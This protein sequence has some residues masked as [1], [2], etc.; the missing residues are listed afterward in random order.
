MFQHHD[1][2]SFEI[3]SGLRSIWDSVRFNKWVVV[4]CTV[5]TLALLILYVMLWPP[6]YQAEATLM[7]EREH[8]PTRDVYYSSWNVFRKDDARTELALMGSGAVLMELVD[9]EK[10]TYADVHHTFLD[11][12]KFLW[13][14]SWPGRRY[15][16]LKA[17]INPPPPGAVPPTAE[18]IDRGRTLEAIKKSVTVTPVAESNVGLLMVKAPSPKAAAIANTLLDTYLKHRKIRHSAEAQAAFDVLA[19]EVDRAAG[20]VEVAAAKRLAFLE[21]HGLAFDFNQELQQQQTLTEMEATVSANRSKL[22]GLEASLAK[23]EEQLAAETP[24]KKLATTVQLN[25][26][27]ESAK[28]KRLELQMALIHLEGRYRPDAPEVVEVKREIQELDRI[29]AGTAENIESGSTAGLN[30]IHENLLVTRNTI[31]AELSGLRAAIPSMERSAARLR[32]HL[33]EMPALQQE[34]RT[35][36]THFSAAHDMYQA[37]LIKRAQTQV[38]LVT[39]SDGPPAMRV[40]D[41]AAAPHFKSWP[42]MKLLLP[43]GLLVGLVLGVVAAVVKSYFEAKVHRGAL[44][45]TGTDLPIYS[46]I[47]ISTGRP[48]LSV[49]PRVN[50]P[51][52]PPPA[53]SEG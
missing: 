9:K 19:S 27:R 11:H 52:A 7:V 30:A 53:A 13:D 29:I 12:A 2:D 33:T 16:A 8:D 49:V 41:Y 4:L 26:L 18:E 35:L 5:L 48:A 22:A 47:T 3:R 6:V 36:D 50:G 32:R 40:V 46:T 45:G 42:K 14:T 23:I 51:A 39:A 15:K 20:E 38:T 34:L 44:E 24:V 21:R 37:L 25:G 31:I 28:S 1:P 17:W 10:L 43:A